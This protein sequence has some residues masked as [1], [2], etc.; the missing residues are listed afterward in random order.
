MHWARQNGSCVSF[1][2]IF[3]SPFFSF[4]GGLSIL[5]FSD[6]HFLLYLAH[7]THISLVS[8][9]ISPCPPL[10]LVH[11][12]LHFS[13]HSYSL[14]LSF[15][16][17]F[18]KRVWCSG[19]PGTVQSPRSTVRYRHSDMV[20]CSTYLFDVGQNGSEASFA[21]REEAAPLCLCLCLFSPRPN[22][23]SSNRNCIRT[24]LWL[25]YALVHVQCRHEDV[26]AFMLVSFFF[27]FSFENISFLLLFFIYSSP[28]CPWCAC[29]LT[30]CM[31]VMTVQRCDMIAS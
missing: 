31:V 14:F 30:C 2:D 25:A 21:N 7:P 13:V 5:R 22:T 26:V 10:A 27:F 23:I 4:L 18:L 8:T 11:C 29:L 20:V 9:R 17:H 24:G 1:Y 12:P 3:I 6:S 15:I 19:F 16:L 28:F